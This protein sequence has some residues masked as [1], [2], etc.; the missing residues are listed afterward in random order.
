MKAEIKIQECDEPYAVIYTEEITNEVQRV[1]GYLRSSSDTVIGRAEDKSYVLGVDEIVKV[2]VQNEHTYI[3]TKNGRFMTNKRLYE[4]K[5]AL[6]RAF[7]Q[8]S[9]SVIVRISECESVESDFGGM[10]VLHLKNG[11]REYV[12]RHY[13][14]E[15]KKSIGL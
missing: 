2:T 14:P 8:I 1:L 9:K 15:F 6:G 13:V 4:M 12:S 3:H 11:S 10:M 7:V 5:K